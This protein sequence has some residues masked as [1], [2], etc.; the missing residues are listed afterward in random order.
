[1]ETHVLIP[2]HD[3]PPRGVSRIEAQIWVAD[4]NWL[5]LHWRIRNAAQL[6]LPPFAGKGRAD[7][8]WLTTCFELFLRPVGGD[9]YVEF[10]FSPSERWAAYDFVTY[11]EGMAEL[12]QSEEPNC[13]V[14]VGPT[15]AVFDAAV[16]LSGLP[17]LPWEVGLSAV[18]EEAGGTKSYWALAHPQGKPD[19]H[20]PACFAAILA[21]PEQP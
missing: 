17:A 16:S 10:N 4:R 2:H 12:A 5:K 11:R 15:M 13:H 18:I 8:L 6:V 9:S 21:A 20:A 19:F 14:L 3:Y 7:K 1:M